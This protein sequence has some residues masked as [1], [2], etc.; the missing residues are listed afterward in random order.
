MDV[1]KIASWG[2]KEDRPLRDE[3]RGRLAGRKFM[4]HYRESNG[5]K[6][7][8]EYSEWFKLVKEATPPELRWMW[9]SERAFKDEYTEVYAQVAG[10]LILERIA[11]G[12]HFS[13]W[14]FKTDISTL[15]GWLFEPACLKNDGWELYDRKDSKGKFH[16]SWRKRSG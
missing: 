16:K 3:M 10:D 5:G 15:Y 11:K 2:S 13:N 8:H 12:G 7:D 14:W 6:D 4:V 9:E 1:S